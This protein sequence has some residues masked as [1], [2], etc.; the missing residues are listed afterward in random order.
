MPLVPLDLIK[1]WYVP[2][3]FIYRQFAFTFRNAL[4]SKK[5]PK[6]AAVCALFWTAMFSMT[7]LRPFVGFILIVRWT[8]RL[9]HLSDALR[10]TDKW[11]LRI[12]GEGNASFGI[13]TFLMSVL[14]LM[15]LI[16]GSAWYAALWSCVLSNT[17]SL[18]ILGHL[19]LPGA[20]LAAELDDR[21]NI[22]TIHIKWGFRAF[23]A[24]IIGCMAVARPDLFMPLMDEAS[25]IV[26]YVGAIIWHWVAG[27]FVG[28]GHWLG[29]LLYVLW[30]YWP[31]YLGF[32]AFMA[33][34]AALAYRF[35]VSR[36]YIETSY[37]DIRLRKVRASI[38]D[39]IA[40]HVA[41]H[42]D[43]HLIISAEDCCSY[44]KSSD[45]GWRMT[46]DI[47]DSEAWLKV[48]VSRLGLS[49]TG[50]RMDQIAEAV[51]AEWRAHK[52]LDKRIKAWNARVDKVAGV[53]R[54]VNAYIHGTTA[55]RWLH[56]AGTQVVT[57]GCVVWEL[58]KAAKTKQCPW[59]LFDTGQQPVAPQVDAAPGGT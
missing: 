51:L 55:Y 36:A 39:V 49:I 52:T 41:F 5:I 25:T 42:L 47:V 4:W 48:D 23:G 40:R 46:Y 17:V 50:E 20:I 56:I 26:S 31:F 12:L 59:M 6:G 30:A 21:S 57:L 44:A 29:D 58:I 18:F 35:D 3:S 43:R 15:C 16:I 33:L 32:A 11:A 27:L 22:E 24:L 8:A 2:S 38:H 7:I 19:W 13:P 9:L 53:C 14:T 28:S 1:T 37:L 10:W 45:I 34:S 54:R